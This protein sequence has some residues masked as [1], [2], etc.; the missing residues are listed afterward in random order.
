MDKFQNNHSEW[1]N[2]DR[3]LIL[4]FHLCKIIENMN[5]YIV[6]EI[7]MVVA[8]RVRRGNYKKN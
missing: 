8:W 6:Y 1:Q 3:I 2:S 7:K 5:K 4:Q